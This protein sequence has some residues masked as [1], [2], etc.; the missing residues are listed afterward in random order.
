MKT[1]SSFCA[2]AVLV[3]ALGAPAHAA[4]VTAFTWLGDLPGYTN[5]SSAAAVSPDGRYVTGYSCSSAVES[6]EAFVWSA[7]TGMV[8]LG[9][10]TGF[11]KGTKGYGV[12]NTGAV[13]GYSGGGTNYNQAFR[14]SSGTGMVGLGDLPG[15]T[16]NSFGQAISA[17]GGTIAGI[18]WATNSLGSGWEAFRWTSGGMQGLSKLPAATYGNGSQ[19]YGISSDGS[20]VVGWSDYDSTARPQAFRCVS[21]SGMQ[22]LGGLASTIYSKAYGASADGG[23]VVGMSHDSSGYEAAFR[24]TSDGG[25]QALGFLSS[26]YHQSQAFACSADGSVVIGMSQASG[27]VSTAFIWDAYNGMRNL[28]TLLHTRYLSGVNLYSDHGFQLSPSQCISADGRTIVGTAY[29]TDPANSANHITEAF[30]VTLPS[31]ASLCSASPSSMPAGSLL[32]A[33]GSVT[34][35]LVVPVETSGNAGSV[36]FAGFSDG[37]AVGMLLDVELVAGAKHTLADVAGYLAL[38]GAAE[39]FSVITSDP[40]LTAHPDFE[41]LLRWDGA[42]TVAPQYFAYDLLGFEDVEVDRV[43]VAAVPEPATT[44]ILGLGSLAMLRRKKG[45][46]AD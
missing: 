16:V 35:G 39:G 3:L 20:T 22:G 12:S 17:D 2:V 41:L 42:G 28:N 6:T 15:L 18:G 32:F 46:C 44:A 30:I 29:H 14:W 23:V 5:Y 24:W 43:A 1:N 40:L 27:G 9:S 31:A 10:L 11:P 8:G 34:P 7:G 21:G 36:S 33:A 19:A 38:A 13:T 4:P 37:D 45:R 25:M 26:Y